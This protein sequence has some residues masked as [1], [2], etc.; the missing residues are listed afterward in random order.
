MRT[1]QNE[2]S[3]RGDARPTR[4]S[5]ATESVVRRASPPYTSVQAIA[6]ARLDPRTESTCRRFRSTDRKSAI[7]NQ[8]SAILLSAVP[9]RQFPDAIGLADN[10][11]PVAF[12]N[13]GLGPWD[14][15]EAAAP[16]KRDEASGGE[17]Q[18][19]DGMSN[20]CSSIRIRL[21]PQREVPVV[22]Q[23]RFLELLL[24]LRLLPLRHEPIIVHAFRDLGQ[25]PKVLAGVVLGT[26]QE[27]NGVN[28]VLPPKRTP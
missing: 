3:A 10:R 16:Y 6:L 9:L 4:T 26:D 22:P 18:F 13:D 1:P 7:G 5:L 28:V 15:R 21:G 12:F 14:E 17:F 11:N 19:P 8:Q 2:G 27:E 25:D 24:V 23:Q 20:Q